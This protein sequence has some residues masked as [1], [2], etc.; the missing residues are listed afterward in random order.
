MWP[1]IICSEPRKGICVAHYQ[2]GCLP[3]STH[4]NWCKRRPS[5]L[6]IYCSHTPN[7]HRV[8]YSKQELL[9]FLVLWSHKMKSQL[10]W[11]RHTARMP[12]HQLPKRLLY[13]PLQHEKRPQGGQKKRFKD[14]SIPE[15][16]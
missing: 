6:Y 8:H 5:C 12:H 9:L 7:V 14:K 3:K 2:N 4:C 11:A 10:P 13:R 1:Q 16:I 15:S